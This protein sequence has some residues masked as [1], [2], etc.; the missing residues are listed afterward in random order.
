MQKN[1]LVKVKMLIAT[2]VHHPDGD[3]G[4]EAQAFDFVDELLIQATKHPEFV[5]GQI[6][7][8]TRTLRRKL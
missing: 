5:A 6:E 3:E 2:E 7:E 4:S 1:Y 8:V